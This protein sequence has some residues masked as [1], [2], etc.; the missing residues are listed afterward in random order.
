MLCVVIGHTTHLTLS[1]STLDVH[2]HRRVAWLGLVSIG[3]TIDRH[4]QATL[5]Y[6]CRVVWIPAQLNWASTDRNGSNRPTNMVLHCVSFCICDDDEKQTLLSCIVVM[7]NYRRIYSGTRACTRNYK[8]ELHHARMAATCSTSEEMS[9]FAPTLI[10][11]EGIQR[12]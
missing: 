2:V 8:K 7:S 1:S 6:V 5:G 12:G 4:R 10:T 11:T 3:P 9:V